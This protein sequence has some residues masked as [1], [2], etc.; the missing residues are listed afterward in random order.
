MDVAV[1]VEESVENWRGLNLTFEP[2]VRR[3]SLFLKPIGDVLIDTLVGPLLIEV[4]GISRDDAM[5][6]MI[7]KDEEIV[8]ACP[9]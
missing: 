1:V 3:Q 7:I 8:S 6:L 9:F 2:I 4:C 5:K